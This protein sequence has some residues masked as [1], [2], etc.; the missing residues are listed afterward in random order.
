MN[1]RILISFYK[2]R[3]A[4]IDRISRKILKFFFVFLISVLLTITTP[5]VVEI[6]QLLIFYP[7]NP[8]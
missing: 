8:M 3:V 6:G 2:P 7:K 5:N 4:M 1:A